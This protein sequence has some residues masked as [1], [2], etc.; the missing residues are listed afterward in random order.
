MANRLALSLIS[1]NASWARQQLMRKTHHI[2]AAQEQFLKKLLRAH[3][4]TALGQQFRL[5]DIRTLEDFRRRVPISPYEFYE[6][7]LDRVA[8]GESCVLNPDPVTYLNLTSGSTGRKKRVPVTQRFQHTRQ[9]ANLASLGYAISSLKHHH[10][11]FGPALL[12]DSAKPQGVTFAGIP[13][14]SVSAGRLHLGTGQPEQ[15]FSPPIE[16]LEISEP[17]TRQ[18]VCLLFALR[19]RT[20]KGWVANFPMLILRTCHF[21][22]RYADE[23]IEDL[24]GGTIAPWLKI[25]EPIR[26]RLEQQWSADKTRAAELAAIVTQAGRLTPRTVWPQLSYVTT[27]RG[28]TSDFYL[29]RF[30]DYFGDIPIFGG[31]YES[32]EATFSICPEVNSEGG[33]LA[34]E[35]G[36]FEFIPANQWDRDQPATLLPTELT[37]GDLY[38]VLVTNYSGFYRYDSGDVVEVVGFYNQ[39]PLIVFRHRDGEVLSATLEKTTEYHLTQ[40]MQRLQ[41]E[42]GLLFEDFCITLSEHEFPARYVVNLELAAGYT[43]LKPSTFLQRFD[44]WLCQVNRSYGKARQSH[45]PP[46][47]LRILPSCSFVTLRQRQVNR[48]MFDSH[49]KLPHLCQD[50]NFLAAIPAQLEVNLNR[51]SLVS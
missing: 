20:L 3:A 45:L 13:Y 24:Q 34:L 16:A 22:E 11:S 30:P 19:N 43:L 26:D 39:S 29:Q 51:L 17:L 32:A 15:L 18:Y 14:G 36:F 37:V 35:S 40:V 46:P 12:T 6:P 33:I 7:Y 4:S 48:G 1:L 42:F 31:V 41:Q 27:A 9:Q 49:L 10:R 50:H 23:L 47:C 5:Q 38:R 44:Y 28:G 8:Q 25:D 21:L 2:M